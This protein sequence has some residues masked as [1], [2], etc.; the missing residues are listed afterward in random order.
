MI[1]FAA[2]AVSVVVTGY[3]A[4]SWLWKRLGADEEAPGTFERATSGVI[5]GAALWLP[6]TGS[7]RSLIA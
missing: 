3:G 5:A 7:S 6:R 4:A 1:G 2:V